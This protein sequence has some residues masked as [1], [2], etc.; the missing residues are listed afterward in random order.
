MARWPGRSVSA[1]ILREILTEDR[2]LTHEGLDQHPTAQAVSLLRHALVDVGV[3]EPRDTAWVQF[4]A[5]TD[6]FLEDRPEHMMRHLGPFCRWH[7][8]ARTRLL[9]ARNG[10]T[11]GTFV[12]AR[13]ICRT[14][15]H[16]L[17]DLH[18][19]QL[20]LKTA[21][22]HAVESYLDRHPHNFE[23]LAVFL[24]WVS[25]SG[26][27]DRIHPIPSPYADPYTA[28]PID[29][30]RSWMRRFA[31]DETIPLR[32]RICALIAGITGRPSTTIAGLTTASII[33]DGDGM[34]LRLGTTP[35]HLPPPLPALIRRQLATPRRW[36]TESTW[37]FPSK[38][39]AGAHV[40]AS[41]FAADLQNLSCSIVRLRGAALLNLA[42]TMPVAPLCD[43]T[44]MSPNVAARW[45]IVAASA[46]AQYPAIRL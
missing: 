2:E 26:A 4:V 36:D 41:R 6:T 44:G 12:R 39:R 22:Q 34:L 25:Q 17:D 24:R 29:T 1:A 35:A 23:P 15:A 31:T 5:W 37:L 38:L 28:Y 27:A 11:D 7:V 33:D 19:H 40:H 32:T 30:Y 46:Y 14:A 8:P 3:L 10:I 43:L 21:S 9:I 18:A 45:Q 13:R 16:F 42:A 20:E